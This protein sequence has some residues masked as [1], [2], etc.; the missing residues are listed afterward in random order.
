MLWQDKEDVYNKATIVN[1]ACR[2]KRGRGECK[3]KKWFV[4]YRIITCLVIHGFLWT[5]LAFAQ[6][7]YLKFFTTW[8]LILNMLTTTLIVI[9]HVREMKRKRNRDLN[10]SSTGDTDDESSSNDDSTFIKN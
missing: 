2:K 7:E 3:N 5:S 4:L 1:P 9:A 8:S 10:A 6:L